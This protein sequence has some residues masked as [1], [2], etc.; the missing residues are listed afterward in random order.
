MKAV[1]ESLAP[2]NSDVV[3]L[4]CTPMRQSAMSDIRGSN[5]DDQWSRDAGTRKTRADVG[6]AC[7]PRHL[8]SLSS[9]Q[10]AGIV[11]C[12]QIAVDVRVNACDFGTIKLRFR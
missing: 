9:A 7:F 1:L 11:R 4:Y 10:T 6:H 2:G 5:S 3:C 12:A 8:N